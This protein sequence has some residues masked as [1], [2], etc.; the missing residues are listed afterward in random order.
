MTKKDFEL[1]LK[2]LQLLGVVDRKGGQWIVR[3]KPWAHS[4]MLHR[5]K[6]EL[7]IRPKYSHHGTRVVQVGLKGL[8]GYGKHVREEV[9]FI[10][11][12]QTP[13]SKTIQKPLT[14]NQLFVI[15]RK[16]ARGELEAP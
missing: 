1:R 12:R 2:E 13:T 8:S 6:Q 16:I 7:E 15:L 11:K 3:R 10:R 14:P 9:G 4:W 5:S